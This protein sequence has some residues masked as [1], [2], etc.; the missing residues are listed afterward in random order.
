MREVE[1]MSMMKRRFPSNKFHVVRG[2][3]KPG[4]YRETLLAHTDTREEA[5]L[6]V[7][8]VPRTPDCVIDVIRVGEN[9]QPVE[10]WNDQ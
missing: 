3:F 9:G 5:E 4:G 6:A 7:K 8:I 10:R 1:K 2:E